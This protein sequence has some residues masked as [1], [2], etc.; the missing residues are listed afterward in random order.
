V[1]VG[2]TIQGTHLRCT[3][4]HNM[5]DDRDREA[6]DAYSSALTAVV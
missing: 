5:I 3:R 6:L 2:L 1:Q 4:Y